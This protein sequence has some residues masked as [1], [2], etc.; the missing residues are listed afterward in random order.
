MYAVAVEFEI[1]PSQWDAFMPL[2]LENAAH[3]RTGEPGCRQ[4]DVCAGPPAPATVFLYEL[5]DDRAAFDA[6]LASAHF[7]AFATA[8]GSMIVNRRI[9]TWERIAPLP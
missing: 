2:M 4:F 5:Y 9:T 6:H 3:S 7:K 8:T 1:D